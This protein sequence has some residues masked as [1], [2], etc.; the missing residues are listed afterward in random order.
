MKTT[1]RLTQSPGLHRAA[2]LTVNTVFPGAVSYGIS[3]AFVDANLI[4][5]P[6]F[7]QMFSRTHLLVSTE[8]H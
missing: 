5:K 8:M 3:N 4:Y 6:W 2:L 7:R 1:M